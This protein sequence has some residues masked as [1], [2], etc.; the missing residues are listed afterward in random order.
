M[1]TTDANRETLRQVA[2]DI[3]SMGRALSLQTIAEEQGA[4]L[5]RSADLF[6]AGLHYQSRFV[7]EQ[8]QEAR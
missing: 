7:A 3:Q 1:T 8:F 6:L 4:A 2:T 5:E